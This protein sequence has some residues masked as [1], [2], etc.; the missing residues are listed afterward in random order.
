MYTI[1]NLKQHSNNYHNN[2][3]T[4]KKDDKKK[5]FFGKLADK[6]TDVT[7]TKETESEKLPEVTEENVQ[8]EK[9]SA[10]VNSTKEELRKFGGVAKMR[11]RLQA[12][13]ERALKA[14]QPKMPPDVH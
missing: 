7:Q 9:I 12:K 10:G 8:E 1:K 3:A 4:Q 6:I 14:Q 2:M 5:G 13:R 11:A